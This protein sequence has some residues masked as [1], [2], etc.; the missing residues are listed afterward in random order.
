MTVNIFA[1]KRRITICVCFF[2]RYNLIR[3]VSRH[4]SVSTERVAKQ[5]SCKRNGPR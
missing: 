3:D 5:S 2:V 4:V 1:L